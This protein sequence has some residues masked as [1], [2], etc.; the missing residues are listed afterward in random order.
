MATTDGVPQPGA[1]A[2]ESQ[3][4]SSGGGSSSASASQSVTAAPRWKGRRIKRFRLIDELG[5]GAMGRVFLA[6]D[7][8]LKRHVALK[9]LPAK[10][11]DGRPNQRSEKLIREARSAATL[12]HP[13]AVTIHE[14]D[15]N[16]GVHYIAMELVEGGDLERLV[17]MSGPMEHIRACQLAAEAAEAIQHA[18]SRGIIHRDIK[19]ANLL[20]T[21]SGRCKVCDFGL[22]YFGDAVDVE[23]RAKCV[24]TP[25][26]IAPEVAMGQGATERSDIYALGCTMFF[27]LAGKTPYAGT[28]AQ[29]LLKLHINQPLPDLRKIRPDVPEKLIEA[30]EQACSKDPAKRFD[31]AERFGKLLRTFTIPTEAQSSSAH[32]AN[33]KAAPLIAPVTGIGHRSGGGSVAAMAEASVADA[34]QNLDAIAIAAEEQAA[35]EPAEAAEPAPSRRKLGPIQLPANIPP[36]AIYIGASAIAAAVLISL[37]VWLARDGS[38][39][40]SALPGSSNASASKAPVAPAPTPTFAGPDAT[41]NGSLERLDANGNVLGWFVHD[42]FK[43]HVK[44]ITEDGNQFFRLHN[45]DP[46]KTVFVDQKINVDPSWKAITVSV[47]MRATNFKAGKNSAHDARVALAFRDAKDARVGQWPP[48]PNVKS[49]SPWT[50]RVITADVPPGATSLYIQLAIFNATGTADFDD[51]KVVP[52]QAQ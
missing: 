39:A 38:G 22:A 12:E 1:V 34:S 43:T 8:V 14:I 48:V 33:V 20:L 16:S 28:S 45:D 24:G 25:H 37:G 29:D 21:R 30:I 17:R 7:T 5:R 2:T 27:L 47:R 3:P 46:A 18:H 36:P 42:R 10:H 35:A 49:D 41:L 9:L 52:Q 40:P 4:G 31:S 19:P 51:I 15:E 6:E 32:L 23:A 13:N 11:R 44:L 26:F 50:E